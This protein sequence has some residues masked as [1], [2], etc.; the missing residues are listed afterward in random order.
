[1]QAQEREARQAAT[2]AAKLRRIEET[3]KETLEEE[4][5]QK[6]RAWDD[7][8]DDHPAGYGNSKTRPCAI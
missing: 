3:D 4:A 2:E 8:T 1:V 5:L 7:W 6:Q